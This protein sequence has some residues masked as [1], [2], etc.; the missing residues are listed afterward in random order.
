MASKSIHHLITINCLLWLVESISLGEKVLASIIPIINNNTPCISSVMTTYQCEIKFESASHV[1]VADFWNGSSDPYIIA[2]I[3]RKTKQEL[4]F[5]TSTCRSTRDPKW[6]DQDVWYVGGIS[7]GQTIELRM[8]DE[9]PRKMSDDRI[10]VANLK[11]EGLAELADAQAKDVELE[12]QKR[13]ASL[14]VYILTYTYS[15]LGAQDLKKQSARVKISLSVKKDEKQRKSPCLIGPIRYDIHFS[16]ML[17]RLAQTKGT[18]SDV[19]CFLGYQM[20]L[21]DVPDCRFPYTKKR[22]EIVMMYSSGIRG[23]LIRRA[24]RSQHDTIYGY[25]ARTIIGSAPPEDAAARFLEMTDAA[26]EAD[27]KQFTYAITVDGCFHFTR[28]GK[29][30]AINHLSKHAMHSNT[31][32][33][34]VYSGEFF[35]A[36]DQADDH[37]GNTDA[38]VQTIIKDK[39]LVNQIRRGTER[40]KDYAKQQREHVRARDKIK[41]KTKSMFHKQESQAETD[42]SD[43]KMHTDEHKHKVSDFTLVI[44][45]SSGT[46]MPD[47]KNL[48][49]LKSF[50]ESNFPGLKIKAMAQDDPELEELKKTRKVKRD[51]KADE[52]G[53]YGQA[54]S[55]ISSSSNSIASVN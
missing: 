18:G 25:D 37:H 30:F 55:S 17:G 51:Q 10:G 1:P 31:A 36:R 7:E 49:D 43:P 32:Q 35:F 23:T 16:P 40:I 9:D 42:Q 28:T 19:R 8:L 2:Y 54:S 38:K 29:Q 4:S 22:S 15:W 53:V 6:P 41:I 11:L 24:L 21:R 34:V 46:F 45:N 14:K 20:H 48:P 50:L 44:D 27:S 13:K 26:S 47:A 12:V 52:E 5:R 33:E 3:N 39:E